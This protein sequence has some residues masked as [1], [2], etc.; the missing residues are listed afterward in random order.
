MTPDGIKASY[1]EALA[2]VGETVTVRRYTG[3]G[4]GRVWFE[5][6]ALA[7]VSD[8]EPH[9]LVGSVQQGDRKVIILA[10]DLE[11][12][13]FPLPVTTNDRL[14]VR[15]KELAIMLCDDS[16]RRVGGVL[17]AYQLTARG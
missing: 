8:Y 16:S 5:A 3:I 9:E 6:D 12:K 1:R 17:V 2:V 15:G 14:L 13:Q 4:P 11:R 7:R 10:Q